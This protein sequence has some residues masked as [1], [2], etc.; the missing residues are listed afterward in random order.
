MR[1]RLSESH[2][3]LCGVVAAVVLAWFA[4]GVASAQYTFC[5]KTSYALSAAVGYVDDE[6]LVT[7]GWWRLR[8][9][10]CKRVLSDTVR[11]GR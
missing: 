8:A 6:D 1:Y 11:A 4:G 5:N 7:R 10:E 9:G 3:L 2:A